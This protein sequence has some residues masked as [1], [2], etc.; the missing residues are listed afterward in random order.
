MKII[1][2]KNYKELS[3]VASEIIIN[4][5]NKKPNITIGFATG[6]TPKKLYK[7][8]IKAYKKNKVDFSKIKTF[9]LDEFYPIENNNKK[10][11]S[12]YMFKRLFNK[13]NIPKKN[14]NLLNGNSKTPKKECEDYEKKI[15]NNPINIQILGIGEN[16]HIGFN[17]PGSKY[18]SKTRIVELIHI[19]GRALTIGISTIMKAKNIILLASGK[20]KA[21][22]IKAMLKGK[23]GEDV[24]ASFL[25]KHKNVTLIIDK[26][27]GS[28][29]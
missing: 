22:V 15:K 25:R 20:S 21:K 4:E 12:R 11:Y 3:N 23:I 27:A 16:G 9:N 13:I 2:V 6:N 18:N 8:L 14:I 10:S 5:I 24:P 26:G 17:E 19:K 29:L 28:L 7:N 1:K